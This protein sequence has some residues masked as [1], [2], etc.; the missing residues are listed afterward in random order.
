MQIKTTT[1]ID[2]SPENEGLISVVIS[3][4]GYNAWVGGV[5]N[6]AKNEAIEGLSTE[7]LQDFVFDESALD[8][9]PEAFL[10]SFLSKD[11]TYRMTNLIA[12]AIDSYFGIAG[13]ATAETVKGLLDTAIQSTVT[14]TE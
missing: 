7:E 1:T 2:I 14:I 5:I 10:K 6:K 4:L 8:V 13:K 3:Q 11:S 9:T 12:P